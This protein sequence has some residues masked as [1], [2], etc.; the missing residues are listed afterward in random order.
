MPDLPVAAAPWVAPTPTTPVR[1]ALTVPGSK[2]ATARAYILAALAD[3]PSVLTGVLDARDTRLMRAALVSLGVGFADVGE[4]VVRVTPPDAFAPGRVEC[5]LAGTVM[6]FVPGLSALAD[7][8]TRFTGDPE[9]VAR[10]VAPLLDGLAQVG[11]RVDHPQSLPFVVH[12]TGAV[13]GG[14]ATIDASA[15]SQFVSGL[16]LPAARFDA[17]LT[18]RHSGGRLPSAPHIGLTLAMLADRGVAAT[19]SATSWRI[20]PGPIAARDETIEPDLMNAA[21]FLA[22]ALVT[23]GSVTVGWPRH[24]LQA[25]ELVLDTLTALGGRVER[26]DGA[27][28]VHGT[29]TITGADLDLS[30]ASELTCVAAALLAL[31]DRPGSI[32][33]VGHI[34]HH[35]TDRLAALTTELGARGAGITPT[36]DGL[37]V[38][39]APLTG[40]PWRTYA[41]HRMAHAGAVLGLAVPGVVVD[42]IGATTKTI[43]GFDDR[44]R[45][46]VGA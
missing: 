17:G 8:P 20:E 34:R 19:A 39:P 6:R 5:G 42:D 30:R 12:G 32:R 26:A 27:V 22:A 16:L 35:E 46:L 1:G 29:G 10:P 24:T 23:G 15:S 3:G 28:T 13:A 7:G 14:A 45:T 38:R 43:A 4:G 44:W 41:D 40:G 25:A 11:V 33:G 31:A 2:S 21:V 36:D 18:L 9:A 37:V